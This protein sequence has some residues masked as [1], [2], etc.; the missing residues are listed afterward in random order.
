MARG[1][2]KYKSA[3]PYNV[4]MILLVPTMKKVKGVEKPT[5]PEPKD[6]FHFFGSFR[7]FGGT[8]SNINEVYSVQDT[9]TIDTWYDPQF[10][11][12]CRIV[13]EETGGIYEIMGAPEDIEM[14]H[15][16]LQIRVQRLGGYE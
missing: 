11:A 6:G 3:M 4:A 15:Q 10:R 14:R 16:F 8:E 5:Y 7:T 9:A 2:R 1:R 12:N 13:V